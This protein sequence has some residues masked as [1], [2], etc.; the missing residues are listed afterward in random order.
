[1]IIELLCGLALCSAIRRVEP[2]HCEGLMINLKY[3]QC[4]RG[5]A[6][7]ELYE[8]Q[9]L[10]QQFSAEVISCTPVGVQLFDIVLTQTAF[11]PEG[12]GQPWDEGTLLCATVANEVKVVQVQKKDGVIVHGC[13]DAIP[14]GTTVTGTIDWSRRFDLMQQHSGE[15]IV[16]GIA[17]RLFGCENVGFHMGKD[18]ITI[19]FD[20]VL[21][22][23]QIATIEQRA[24]QYI[25]ENHPVEI[26]YPTA[27]QLEKLAYRSKKELTG[28]VRIVTFP[29]ADCCACCGTHVMSSGQVG[30]VKLL[31]CQKFR[32]GV[33]IELVCG[34]RALSYLSKVYEQNIMISRQLSAKPLETSDAVLKMQGEKEK[35]HQKKNMLEKSLL[36]YVV[37]EQKGK[38]HVCL[39]RDELSGD[40]VRLLAVDVSHTISG[41]VFCLAEGER[42]QFRYALA[43]QHLDV[44]AVSAELVRVFQAKGGGTSNLV[45][46]TICGERDA[47]QEVFH[48]VL[49]EKSV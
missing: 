11:Y 34:Q 32:E 19:D 29:E 41:I 20:V 13:T 39:F 43:S 7:M 18:K 3:A 25:W 5:E 22:E 1:M 16:S 28:E 46:G 49:M 27:E 23:Q 38:N 45:Q 15:H 2:S 48:K 10:T 31:S 33:R 47:I 21:E 44:K 24:N 40:S 9:V 17:H 4:K 35:L 42:H 8:Q 12:G 37:E 26:S 6:V 14:V 30:F 36:S